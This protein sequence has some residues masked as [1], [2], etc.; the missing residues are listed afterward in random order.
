MI[1]KKFSILIIVLVSLRWST[2]ALATKYQRHG[3][4][5]LSSK[6]VNTPCGVIEYADV[7]TGPVILA[8]HGAG[9]GFDQSLDVASDLIAALIFL[10]LSGIVGAILMCSCTPQ[11]SLGR[12][13]RLCCNIRCFTPI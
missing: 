3:S 13:R 7:G 9:G 6:F 8:I 4:T 1:R 2:P 11:A 10:G 5:A 12:C